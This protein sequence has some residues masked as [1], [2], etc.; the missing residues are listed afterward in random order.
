MTSSTHET[1]TRTGVA[2]KKDCLYLRHNTFSDDIPIV[3]VYK[4]MGVIHDQEIFQLVGTNPKYMEA[5]SMSLK[6]S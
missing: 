1:R 4:A 5:I 2:Y 3:I 6:E